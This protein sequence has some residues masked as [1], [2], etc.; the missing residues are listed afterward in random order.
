MPFRQSKPTVIP[1]RQELVRLAVTKPGWRLAKSWKHVW[2]SLSSLPYRRH[3]T[4]L[5]LTADK[6]GLPLIQRSITLRILESILYQVLRLTPIWKYPPT[7]GL[8]QRQLLTRP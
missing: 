7:L 3:N 5:H 8:T 6:L 4:L 1:Y 2:G